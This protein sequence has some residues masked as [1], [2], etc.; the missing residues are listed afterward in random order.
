LSKAGL[1]H[2]LER[3]WI[4][5]NAPQVFHSISTDSKSANKSLTNESNKSVNT[6]LLDLIQANQPFYSKILRYEVR[7]LT[8]FL[9]AFADGI[10]V[11][12]L[13]F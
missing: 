9:L 5:M 11:L 6:I 12:A 1:V 4:A 7:K 13:S 10:H 2:Q 3:I 8:F